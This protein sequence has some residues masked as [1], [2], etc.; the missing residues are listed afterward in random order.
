MTDE[1]PAETN[2]PAAA[3][4]AAVPAGAVGSTRYFVP[5]RD[6]DVDSETF[7]LRRAER[8]IVVENLNPNLTQHEELRAVCRQAFEKSGKIGVVLHFP[9]PKYVTSL[10][11]VALR[12]I[13]REARA[14]K[15]PFLAVLH[16]KLRL[17][18][19]IFELQDD[20]PTEDRLEIA[21]QTLNNQHGAHAE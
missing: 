15:R 16:P 12:E 10:F 13:G 11:I 3:K 9:T 17:L 18:L 8:C 6:T 20:I 21:L 1:K 5:G 7:R 19:A 2:K 14:A 4:P